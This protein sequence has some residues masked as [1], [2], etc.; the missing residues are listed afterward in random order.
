MGDG[1]KCMCTFLK[2]LKCEKYVSEKTVLVF[3]DTHYSHNISY[4]L[5][6]KL[7]CFIQKFRKFCK[8]ERCGGGGGRGVHPRKV[9][10][11]GGGSP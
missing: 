8:I 2:L 6:P 10:T 9:C 3:P 1:V 7:R 4:F 5:K 11:Q